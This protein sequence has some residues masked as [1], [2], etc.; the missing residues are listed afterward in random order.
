MITGKEKLI[1]ARHSRELRGRH[2]KRRRQPRDVED[3][4]VQRHAD[5]DGAHEPVVGPRRVGEQRA[6]LGEGVE[7][8]E[9]L[10]HAEHAEAHRARVGVRL[11]VE[12]LARVSLASLDAV[13]E[14][15]QF[16][17]RHHGTFGVGHEPPPEGAHG[18]ETDVESDD[19]IPDEEPSVDDGL[20]GLLGRCRMMSA[21]GVLN[22]SAVAGS[23]SVTRF[24]H[25]S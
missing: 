21:S 15:R 25:S 11:A 9:H 13:L 8:V 7:S 23:P 3:E 10:H 17:P 6:V 5:D 20:V 12:N 1:T 22:P 18:G 19:E 24:T 16:S 2:R 4:T 14:R